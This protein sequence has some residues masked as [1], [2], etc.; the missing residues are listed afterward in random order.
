VD[1]APTNG[2]VVV[3]DMLQCGDAVDTML[4]GGELVEVTMVHDEAAVGGKDVLACR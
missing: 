4:E 3:D 2:E 1:N